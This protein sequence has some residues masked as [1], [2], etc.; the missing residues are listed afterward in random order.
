MTTKPV[1]DVFVDCHECAL[2]DPITHKGTL[3]CTKK[4]TDVSDRGKLPCNSFVSKENVPV[5]KD[6]ILTFAVT[7]TVAVRVRA[8]DRDQAEEEARRQICVSDLDV[9]YD[10]M[11][12]EEDVRWRCV[13]RS[14]D[15]MSNRSCRSHRTER[16]CTSPT[17]SR[18]VRR[19]R[20]MT[21][22]S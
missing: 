19:S 8:A 15:P 14:E 16:T 9:D 10:L 21:S 4:H 5:K 3:V 20:W 1:W 11:E 17:V 6:F 2:S 13:C 22:P 7:G 12:I 18:N